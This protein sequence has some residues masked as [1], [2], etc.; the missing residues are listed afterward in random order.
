MPVDEFSTNIVW[1]GIVVVQSVF[2]LFLIGR[3][4]I[5]YSGLSDSSNTGIDISKKDIIQCFQCCIAWRFCLAI[6]NLV[7]GT[8][9]YAGK[10]GKLFCCNAKFFFS[11]FEFLDRKSRRVGKEC[12]L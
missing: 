8:Y 1:E 2:A 9:R 5:G 10:S 12:R 7:D 6:Q 4:S 11:F 3:K